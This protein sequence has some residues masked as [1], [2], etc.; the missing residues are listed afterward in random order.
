MV[1]KWWRRVEDKGIW[2]ESGVLDVNGTV[3]Q[4]PCLHDEYAEIHALSKGRVFFSK[5]YSWEGSKSTKF[6]VFRSIDNN[7][8]FV[9]AKVKTSKEPLLLAC[10]VFF[11]NA[12][13]PWPVSWRLLP[14]CLWT[15]LNSDNRATIQNIILFF[16]EIKKKKTE[17]S[18]L[19]PE[20]Q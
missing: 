11:C 6:S 5:Y 15:V 16:F 1:C 10:I 18:L 12:I 19:I 20:K 4:S 14:E 2:V 3:F 8:Y 9:N 13:L 7:M 17:A